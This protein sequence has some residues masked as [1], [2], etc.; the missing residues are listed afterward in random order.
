VARNPQTLGVL[1][2]IFRDNIER[3]IG[4]MTEDLALMNGIRDIV[5]YWIEISAETRVPQG[6]NGAERRLINRG[7]PEEDTKALKGFVQARLAEI[8]QEEKLVYADEI[9][10]LFREEG[11]KKVARRRRT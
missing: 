9:F 7:V 10:E 3:Q 5:H 8:S 2:R 1:K 4:A 11:L 6:L